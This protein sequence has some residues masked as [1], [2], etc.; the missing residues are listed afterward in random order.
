MSGFIDRLKQKAVASAVSRHRKDSLMGKFGSNLKS[1]WQFLDGWK[2]WLVAVILTIKV[3][4]ADCAGIGYID[5]ILKALGW[6]PT[7]VAFDPAQAAMALGVLV[8]IGHR[9]AKAVAQYRAGRPLVALLS[10]APAAA[11]ILPFP[12]A[13]ALL[14]LLGPCGVPILDAQTIDPPT[15]PPAGYPLSPAPK[16]TIDINTHGLSIITKGERHEYLGGRIIADLAITSQHHAS[17]RADILGAQDGA[18]AFAIGDYST[19][20]TVDIIG[21]YRYQFNSGVALAAAGGATFSIEGETGAPSDA[22]QYTA[23]VLARLPLPSKTA[24]SG[25][26]YIGGGW[27]GEVG[28]PAAVATLTYPLGPTYFIADYAFPFNDVAAADAARAAVLKFGFSVNVKH[29]EIK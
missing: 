9:L 10:E 1:L 27:R 24:K 29:L 20:R 22:R 18:A 23:V 2:S 13:A 19:Y 4:C 5:A 17:I 28:G 26:L 7:I 8:A 12:P 6:D 11:P 16:A 14:L 3:V 15:N 25:H 21:A